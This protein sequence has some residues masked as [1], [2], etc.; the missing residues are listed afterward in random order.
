[1]PL[2]SPKFFN[3]A[4][5]DAVIATIV[6]LLVSVITGYVVYR[7]A[8]AGMKK[9]VQN[10]LLG[11]AKSA[12]ELTDGDAHQQITEPAQMGSLLYEQ[13]REPYFKLL[14]ANPNV[15]FIYTAIQK[16]DKVYFIMD[17]KLF[18]PDEKV[19]YTDIMTQYDDATEVMLQSFQ[20]QKALVEDQV[21]SDDWGT[22]LSGYAPVFNSK[23]EFVG[24]VGADM[25]VNDYLDQLDRIRKSLL[26]GIGVAAIAS[27]LAGVCVWYVRNAA[28]KMA[29]Q[30]KEQQAQM[31]RIKQQQVEEQKRQKAEAEQQRKKALEDIAGHFE[32]SVQGIIAQV[33]DASSHMHN[34]SED[35]AHIADDT[36]NRSHTVAQAAKTAADTSAHISNAAGEMQSAINEI[37]SQVQKSSR[38]AQ[39]AS[40]QAGQAKQAI[41][42]LSTQS[43]KV[44]EIVQMINKIASQINLLALNATIESARAGEAGKGFTVVA[45]EVKQL[46]SQVNNATDEISGQIDHMR[47]ATTHSVES[48]LSIIQ[49]IDQVS[50]SIQAVAAAVE[51][52]SAVTHEI[53]R[54]ISVTAEGAKN[55]SDNIATV[56]DG[57][58]RTGKTASEVVQL[59]K[60]LNSQ[61]QVLQQKVQEFLGT[62]R[63]AE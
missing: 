54:N 17:S 26:I 4:F 61:S 28:L 12:A 24:I 58:E 57:A 11:I 16:D 15:T 44:G 3:S 50:S 13:I 9:Q 55:I 37:S 18:K 19:E 35:M 7:S 32:Q 25:Q 21:Y 2:S 39:D 29:A 1:M 62:V 30:H 40:S 63:G 14:K 49:I 53:V 33:V 6:L 20:E 27:L 48:V 34:D 5:R 41:E 42:A 22:F 36:K 8:E 46:A 47:I 56:Q 51:E 59:A 45:N 43:D 38:V 23:K 60:T 31:E 52:Q 10:G